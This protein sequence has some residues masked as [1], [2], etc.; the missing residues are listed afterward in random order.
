VLASALH[1]AFEFLQYNGRSNCG[2]FAKRDS[3]DELILNSARVYLRRIAGMSRHEV[4]T[5]SFRR[6]PMIVRPSLVGATAEEPGTHS[7]LPANCSVCTILIICEK[8]T[9]HTCIRC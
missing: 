7:P 5:P 8:V 4:W 1:L 2:S 6:S 3:L 9:Q